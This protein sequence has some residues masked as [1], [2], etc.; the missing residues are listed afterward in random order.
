MAMLKQT[1]MKNLRKI[2]KAN[3]IIRTNGFYVFRLILKVSF[4]FIVGRVDQN[5][6]EMYMMKLST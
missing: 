2:P 4:L 3:N 1:K 6:N 5:D